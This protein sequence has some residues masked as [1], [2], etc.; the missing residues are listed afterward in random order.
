MS[1]ADYMRDY[2]ER[3]PNVRERQTKVDRA[4]RKA[5]AALIARYPAEYAAIL[6]QMRRAEGLD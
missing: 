1:Q 6:R 5:A 3:N 2:R 4:K